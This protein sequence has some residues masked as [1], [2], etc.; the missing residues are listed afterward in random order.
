MDYVIFSKELN[1]KRRIA[2]ILDMSHLPVF[3]ENLIDAV[4]NIT[5]VRYGKDIVSVLFGYQT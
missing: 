2:D 1:I 5:N 4:V 3:M